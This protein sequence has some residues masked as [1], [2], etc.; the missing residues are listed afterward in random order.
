MLQSS[1]ITNDSFRPLDDP[2]II[3]ND[4]FTVAQESKDFI[5]P[6]EF[7]LQNSQFI[8]GRDIDLDEAA[9]LGAADGNFFGHY[10]FPKTSRQDSAPFHDSIWTLLDDPLARQISIQVFRG[11][12]K[13]SILRMF[14]A[15][16]IAYGLSNTILYLGKSEGHATRSVEWLKRHIEFNPI[17]RQAFQI[18]KGQPWSSTEID[19]RHKAFDYPIRILGMGIEGS[20]RGINIDDYRPDL[21]ILDDVIDE[22]NAHTVEARTK[23]NERIFG[24]VA[25]SL[26]PETENPHAKLV[27]LQTPIDSS[28]A[29]EIT[30]RDPAWHSIRISC[31]NANGGSAWPARWTT[32]T[33]LKDKESAARRNML[34]VWLREKECTVTADEAFYFRWENVSLWDLLPEGKLV[35][36]IGIDPSPPKDEAPEKKKR[37]D[38]D[39]EVVSVVGIWPGTSKRYVLEYVVITDPNPEKT[40][41]E[42]RRLARKWKVRG[43]G[44]ESVAYQATL[45]WYFERRMRQTQFYMPVHK[46]DDKREKT[47][48]IRQ[49][50]TDLSVESDLYVHPSMHEFKTQFENYPA[51]TYD[52]VLDSIDIGFEVLL[53]YEL[54]GEEMYNEDN[55][56]DLPSDWRQAP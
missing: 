17:F 15:R 55:I 8:L 16:R 33:L 24:A 48:R 11:G 4:E 26:A 34:S 50:F 10:F 41:M 9:E 30:Q 21:I 32:Q 39:P 31:F 5:H 44:I 7:V 2:E 56:P 42:F 6:D 29:S 13:T 18:E 47:K 19:I 14:V 52:D 12:A 3:L 38:P 22:T 20:V 27:M 53:N 51:V 28:D 25:E 23:M 1:E 40:W 37:K 36:A 43:V 49:R 45:K 35:T 46:L 54:A